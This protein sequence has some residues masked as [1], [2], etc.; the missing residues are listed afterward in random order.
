MSN[1][2]YDFAKEKR[3]RE[4]KQKVDSII[5][6]GKDWFIRNKET[7]IVLVPVVIGGIATVVKVVGKRANLNKEES[8]KNLYCYDR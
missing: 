6:R 4:F 8:L 5:Q 3:R 1:N 2:V 7:V